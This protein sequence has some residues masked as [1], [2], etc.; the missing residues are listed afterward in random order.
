MS[1]RLGA[2][3]PPSPQTADRERLFRKYGLLVIIAWLVFWTA[4]GAWRMMKR[5][6]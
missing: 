4:V 5:D 6:A 3:R 2:P 1:D